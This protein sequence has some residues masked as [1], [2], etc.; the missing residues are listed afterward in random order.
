MFDTIIRNGTVINGRN[1]PRF[2][3]NIGF[4]DDRIGAIGALDGVDAKQTIDATGLIVAPGFIDVHTHSD[5]WLLKN[6]HLPSKTSQGFTTEFLMLDGISYAP[7]DQHTIREWIYY[8]RPLNGLQF[9]DYSGWESIADYMA[10]LDGNTA[11]N[12]ATFIPYANV[13]TL[14]CGFGQQFPNDSQMLQIKQ[15]IRQGMAEGALGISNGLDYLDE[16]FAQTDEWIEACRVMSPDGVYVSHVRYALGT[17][18]GVQEAVEIG[19]KAAVPVHISHLKATSE[20]EAEAI[21]S[22][23]DRVAINEVDFSFDVYPYL[24]SSTMLQYLLP[25]E[26]WLDG[27]IKALGKLTD[28][29]VRARFARSLTHLDLNSVR[30]AWV[31]GHANQKHQ[32]KTLQQ[33]IDETGCAAADALCDLLIEEGMAV[34]LVFH[35]G[36]DNLVSPFLAHDRYMMG[37]DGIYFPDGAIH[38]RQ[39]GSGARLLGDCVRNRG[40]FSLE[41]AVYKMSGFPAARFGLKSRGTL[42][43]GNFA[44]I[45]LFEPDTVADKA[46]YQN[47]HQYAEGIVGLWVNGQPV[48]EKGKHVAQGSF[49]PRGRFLKMER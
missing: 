41:T 18:A 20:A 36:D 49:V 28:G 24:P 23:I 30:I 15:L 40:L 37:S 44:D 7:V 47:P 46:T 8:L 26:V 4:E 34:L 21:L 42:E 25:H 33:Y 3:A 1:Q 39:Y 10:L 27:P 17:L 12:T 43:V 9:S 22:Y 48:I 6:P 13:R 14:A 31:G 2:R 29:L 5:G 45:T 35:L 32:G 16:C 19:Q 11:Q 38:P